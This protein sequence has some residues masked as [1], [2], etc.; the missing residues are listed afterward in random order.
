M[1][2][3]TGAYGERGAFARYKVSADHKV[4]ISCVVDAAE[5]TLPVLVCP[6]FAFLNCLILFWRDE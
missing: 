6:P 2:S 1:P 3:Y 4:V 5:A